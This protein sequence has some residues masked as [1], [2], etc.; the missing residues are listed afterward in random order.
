MAEKPTYE[1]LEQRIDDVENEVIEHEQEGQSFQRTLRLLAKSTK[2]ASSETTRY[3][4]PYGNL[5]ELNTERSILDSVG[6]DI[7]SDIAKDY[8]DL[9]ETSSA[10][11]EI[12]GAYALGIFSSGWCQL[13]DQASRNLCGTNDNRQALDSGKWLCHESCWT[14]ASKVAIE[15]HEAV[16]IECR[17]GIRLYAIPIWAGGEVVG[18]INFGYGDPP[19]DLKKLDEIANRYSVSL[20][21]LVEQA[22]SYENRPPFLVDLAK[23]RLET[24]ARLIGEIVV[25]RRAETELKIRNQINSIFLIHPDERM[26]KEV[27]NV[28]LKIMKSEYGTFGYFREDGSF[29]APAVTRKIYWEKCNVPGEDIISQ[30]RTFGGIWGRSIKDKKTF[31]SNDGPLQTPQGHI[32]IINTI[33]T[34]V[35]FRDELI[36]AI[37][38]ANKPNGY[39]EEDRVILEMIAGIIAPVLYARLQRDK[40]DIELKQAEKALIRSEKK[41]KGIFDFA[42]DALH[43]MDGGNFIAN[44]EK[45]V[46]MYG[47]KTKEQ[48][49]G[50]TPIDIS[51]ERQPDGQLSNV[52][53][54][55]Y[56]KE[57]LGGKPQCFY[58]KHKRRDTG[59]LFDVEVTLCSIVLGD[60]TYLLAAGK[61]ITERKRT[62]AEL[63]KYQDHLE[64]LVGERTNEL[65]SANKK[66]VH[67]IE[68]RK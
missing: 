63:K 47:Y 9:L 65:R 33:V 49:H 43:L 27:L 18:S 29:V 7:L 62:E 3:V 54:I 11:Y 38:L 16:D 8:L 51:P 68:E 66:L 13:L 26:Y 30:M 58:W 48:M 4:P 53:A 5:S 37:H 24:S 45:A 15:A 41:F 61:D 6:A 67:E 60:K 44:N 1:E 2:P 50:T 39:N 55:K 46:R 36:S 31:I 14:D 23:K 52:K 57:A 40:Q 21:D 59:D 32:P 34:P 22:E 17:G 10:V 28:I 42:A 20:D 64:Q 25:R 12:N 56:V 35:I 19:R